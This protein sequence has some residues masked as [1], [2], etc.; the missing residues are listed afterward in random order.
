[1]SRRLASPPLSDLIILKPLSCI[2]LYFYTYMYVH[3]LYTSIQS[4]P[5]L[6]IHSPTPPYFI[7]HFA[8]YTYPIPHHY[9]YGYCLFTMHCSSSHSNS[10]AFSFNENPNEDWTKMS[11]PAER[12]R[13]QN[14]IAQR[15]YREFGLRASPHY[16]VH[17]T[18]HA[19][20]Q[21]AEATTGRF[22][23][24]CGIFR[25]ARSLTR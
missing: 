9:L 14:R 2:L 20:R 1:M 23:A 24:P 6:S 4:Y 19:H 7:F 21:E 11:D 16:L 25:L 12:R 17:S 13:I 22:R 15:N 3:L 10:S 5:S 8:K 18:K